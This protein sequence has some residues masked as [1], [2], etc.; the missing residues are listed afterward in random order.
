MIKMRFEKLPKLSQYLFL[1]I[2]LAVSV[3]F[4]LSPF[5]YTLVGLLAPFFLILLTIQLQKETFIFSTIV[6]LFLS[7]LVTISS[8]HWVYTS[9]IQLTHLNPFFS[10]IFFIF[11]SFFANFKFFLFI[12]V[13]RIFYQKIIGYELLYF[14][15]FGTF[16]DKFV[17]Q[18]FPWYFGN[19]IGGNKFFLN[20]V[21]VFGIYGLS[22]VSFLFSSIFFSWYQTKNHFFNFKNGLISFLIVFITMFSAQ[23]IPM[24]E[25]IKGI[26][27]IGLIQ[28]NTGISSF[29]NIENPLFITNAMTTTARLSIQ[30]IT[31]SKGRLDAL[32]LPETAIPYFGVRNHENID[33]HY[34]KEFHGLVK[35]LS[36]KGYMDVIFNEV[37]SIKGKNYNAISVQSLNGELIQPY[38]KRRL[39]PFGEFLPF[40]FNKFDFL[41][42]EVSNY[43]SGKLENTFSLNKGL[44]KENFEFS[45]FSESDV[46]KIYKPESFSLE[47]FHKKSSAQINWMGALC[48]EAVFPELIHENYIHYKPDLLINLVNDTW[49]GNGLENHQHFGVAK[50]RA[51]ELGIPMIR[52]TLGGITGAIDYK[53]EDLV[54]RLGVGEVGYRIFDIPIQT[55]QTI[56]AKYGNLPLLV[57]FLF[58][59]FL[60]SIE[61]RILL[62]YSYNI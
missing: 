44:D 40:P 9:L 7:L 38:N 47:D 41:F 14:I 32:I 60:F 16:L 54:A 21:P 51:V 34:S 18:V 30:A 42:P 25:N 1:C 46:L 6:Y 20:F 58:L 57:V 23:I 13:Y 15:L 59:I 17:F 12:I 48:Y 3:L 37:Y 26:Y 27:K 5:E 61:R 22:F 24:Q 52:S 4:G 56:Y 45:Q 2:F 35:L 55:R 33:P 10:G 62:K 50:I 28:P 8:F 19:L 43:E 36:Q 31:E 49:F 11:Y 29:E 53:G 39:V